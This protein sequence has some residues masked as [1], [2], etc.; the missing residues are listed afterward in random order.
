MEI[1]LETTDLVPSPALPVSPTLVVTASR[2]KGII[3]QFPPLTVTKQLD[4][5]LNGKEGPLQPISLPHSEGA[6]VCEV[7]QD[8]GGQV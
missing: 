5:P 1:V 8:Q 3:P 7:V 4:A 6:G 2:P